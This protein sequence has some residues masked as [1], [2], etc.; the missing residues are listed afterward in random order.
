MDAKELADVYDRLALLLAAGDEQSAR[1][2]LAEQYPKLPEEAQRQVAL[3]TF[4]DAMKSDVAERE[5]LADIQEDGMTAVEALEK[6]KGVKSDNATD[7][8]D[9]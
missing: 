8:N 1:K 9:E 5:T 3:A 4:I 6:I 7:K 2:Y